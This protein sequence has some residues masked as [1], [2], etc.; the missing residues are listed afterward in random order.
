MKTLKYLKH[1]HNV[2]TWYVMRRSSAVG[3]FLHHWNR[4]DPT[5]VKRGEAMFPGNAVLPS[6][7]GNAMLPSPSSAR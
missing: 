5:E 6:P 2:S 3:L 7:S 1:W 4:G